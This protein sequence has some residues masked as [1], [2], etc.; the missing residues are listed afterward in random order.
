[1]RHFPGSRVEVRSGRLASAL[2]VVLALS[3]LVL[4]TGTAQATWSDS[5]QGLDRYRWSEVTPHAQWAPRAGLQAVSLRGNMYVMGGRTPIDPAVVP[6]PGA[7]DIWSDV[8]R[9]A[10]KGRNWHQ[11]A[12]SDDS[13]WPA[14]AYFQAVT[15]RGAMYVMGGQNFK[16]TGCPPF[17]PSCSDFFN[18]V[19]RS[20]D[21][22]HWRQLTSDAGWTGRAGLSA[23]VHDGAI[24]VMGGSRNDDSAVVGG[25]PAREYFNDVWR[26]TDGR[27]WTQLTTS[28]PWDPRAGAAV[29]SRGDWIY[30]FGGEKGFTCASIPGDPT[31]CVPPYFNDVWRSRDGVTW[32]EVTPAADWS[33]RPGHQCVVLR[34]QFVCFGGFGL[35]GNPVDMWASRDGA[36]WR[37]LKQTPW[38]A[39]SGSDVKYDFDALVAPTRR[40]G[41]PSLFTFGGDRETFDF[42]DPTNYTR[43]DNDVWRF[44]PPRWCRTGA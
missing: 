26:S 35:F 38:D 19:W 32:E 9:S 44:G 7:S 33:A 11:V 20:W 5:G 24:Y 6:I 8:W 2:G 29:V 34:G 21:G 30:L 13:H 22:R 41:P 27:H 28:A 43:V 31:G 4:T 42:S 18:D 12:P 36:D 15:M 16:I 17:A 10:D 1:M 40:A 25:P 37:L 3:G 14:R 23:V 39:T